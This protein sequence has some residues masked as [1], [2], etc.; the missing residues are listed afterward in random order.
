MEKEHR[1]DGNDVELEIDPY[2]HRP[3]EIHDPE[4]IAVKGNQSPREKASFKTPPGK[5]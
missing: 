5:S 3:P 2:I 1:Y 4:Q